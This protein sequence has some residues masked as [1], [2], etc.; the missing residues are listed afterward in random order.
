MAKMN[1][2]PV[3]EMIDEEANYGHCEKCPWTFPYYG[4]YGAGSNYG[5]GSIVCDGQ[6]YEEVSASTDGFVLPWNYRWGLPK[7]KSILRIRRYLKIE[8]KV[9]NCYAVKANSA[10]AILKLL[11]D[12]GA[13]FDIVS[14]GELQRVLTAAPDAAGGS[15]FPELAKRHRRSTSL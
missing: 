7:L 6:D 15:S 12:R 9:Q 14:G 1:N 13:G 2:T 5:P 4:S 11:A 3:I 8:R 10:L